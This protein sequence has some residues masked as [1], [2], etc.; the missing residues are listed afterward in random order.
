[1]KTLGQFVVWLSLAGGVLAAATGYLAALDQPDEQLLGLTLAAPAGLIEKPDGTTL[2]IVDTED[3]RQP[4]VTGPL[5]GELR[6]AG[7]KNVRV[8]QF[9]LRRWRGKWCFLLAL[10]GLLIGGLLTRRADRPRRAAV[11]DQADSPQRILKAVQRAIGQLRQQLP[12]LPDR[13]TQL[14]AIVEQ[15]DAL[16]KTHM[17]TFVDARSALVASLG[18]AGYA[19]LMDSYAAGERQI[20]RAWSAAADQAYAEAV[21]CLAEAARWMEDARKKLHGSARGS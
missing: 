6:A 16:A 19:S 1:M 4:R 11:A 12:E 21:G 5:L 15:L 18:M 2:P 9:S 8:K 14:L 7:V 3:G 20:N 10:V 17:A 13:A